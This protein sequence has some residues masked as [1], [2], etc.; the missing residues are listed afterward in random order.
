MNP[1]AIQPYVTLLSTIMATFIVLYSATP[2]GLRG[3]RQLIIWL[4]QPAI[5]AALNKHEASSHLAAMDA[6]Q[7]PATEPP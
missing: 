2:R 5:T 6:N 7:A 4:V 3:I 1:D